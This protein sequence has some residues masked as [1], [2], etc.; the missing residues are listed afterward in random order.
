MSKVAKGTALD[1]AAF[2]FFDTCFSSTLRA[3]TFNLEASCH[4][5][6]KELDRW[7]NFKPPGPA[8][9]DALLKAFH[10]A[11]HFYIQ[12]DTDGAP[13]EK[14]NTPWV[15]YWFGISRFI[16]LYGVMNEATEQI[17]WACFPQ[18]HTRSQTFVSS[19]CHGNRHWSTWVRWACASE[20]RR[21]MGVVSELVFV[22]IF[23]LS[24]IRGTPVWRKS[25]Q[26]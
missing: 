22:C 25:F 20:E 16:C 8:M 3:N 19:R 21:R 23:S 7:E 13:L 18:Q 2:S 26:T 24:H 10:T 1:Q 5:R 17:M 9:A 6:S 12:R 4:S 11:V 15:F 14:K